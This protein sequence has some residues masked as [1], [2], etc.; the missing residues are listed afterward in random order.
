MIT[1]VNIWNIQL[2]YGG[3]YFYEYLQYKH[4]STF[5]IKIQMETWKP[6]PK[7]MFHWYS[8]HHNIRLGVNT[9]PK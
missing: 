3:R 5:V 8:L 2:F 1:A 7:T 4:H 6:V 9:M